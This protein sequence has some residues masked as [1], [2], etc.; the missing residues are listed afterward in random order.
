MVVSLDQGLHHG[1]GDH[2]GVAD[3]RGD[4]DPHLV[5]AERGGFR[6]PAHEKPPVSAIM[7]VWRIRRPRRG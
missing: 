6:A 5:I 2:L 4:P 1:E 3:L 7:T